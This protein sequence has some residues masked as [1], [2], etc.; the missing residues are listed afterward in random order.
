MAKAQIRNLK[1]RRFSRFVWECLYPEKAAAAVGKRPI[2]KYR[3]RVKF[4]KRR[5]EQL[6]ARSWKKTKAM[7]DQYVRDGALRE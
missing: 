7:L 1:L 3:K 6:A 4:R 5:F 2:K